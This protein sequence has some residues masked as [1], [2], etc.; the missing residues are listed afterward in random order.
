LHTGL[1]ATAGAAASALAST[2][3]QR[4]IAPIEDRIIHAS[5]TPPRPSAIVADHSPSAW[6]GKIGQAKLAN[7]IGALPGSANVR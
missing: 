2:P 4:A 3:A 5:P 6:L 1:A 7:L